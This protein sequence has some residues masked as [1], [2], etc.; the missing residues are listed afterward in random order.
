MNIQISVQ[1]IFFFENAFTNG[2][3]LPYSGSR[4]H[5]WSNNLRSP[6]GHYYDLIKNVNKEN[7]TWSYYEPI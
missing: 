4:V 5:V 1:H 3:K 6:Y 7:H 2:F